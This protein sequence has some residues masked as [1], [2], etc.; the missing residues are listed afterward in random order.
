MDVNADYSMTIDG[1]AARASAAIPVVNPATGEAFAQ[2]PDCTPAQLDEAV[3][4]A[5]TAFKRWRQVPIDERQEL[6]RKAGDVL[7]A[8]ADELARLFTHEQGRPVDGAKQ[9]IQGAAQW[10]HAVST[11]R[12]PVEVSED[13]E[14][15]LIETRYVPLGVICAIAPWNFPVTLSMWKVAPALLAGNTMVLKPS[16]FTPLCTLKIGE[17]FRDVFPPGVLNV[18][19]GGDDL[20]PAMTAHPGFDKISFTGSSATGKRVMESAAKDLKRITLELGG[21]DAAIVL[22]DVDLDEVAQKIFFGAFYNSAQICVATK[23]LYVH[24][25]VY[26]GLRDRL[27]AIAKAVKVGDGAEQGTV[28]GPIQNRRQYDRVMNLLEDARANQLTLIE[29]AAIPDNG[30]FFVPVTIV[31]NPPESSRVVQEEAFGPI[32]P[33][34]KFSDVDEVIDRANASDYG[35]AGA[36][37][38]KDL[39]QA[40]SVARRIETGTVWVNQNLNLR[41]DTPFAGRKQSGFGAE[42]GM[43][44]L[45][46]YMAPQAIYVAK[47]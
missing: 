1:R 12:P 22:P 31:D 33:M 11:M 5:R 42:N 41:P 23:R 13:S 44:G 9:E 26:D 46:E 34:L 8:H 29:G 7:A 15:Q 3:A 39:D 38:S 19:C 35:L 36:I 47:N 17:L 25:A 18:I 20:G 24:E 45:L 43:K 32:L 2:A 10:L 14:Q 4:S 37:W 40:V 16:P 28:L 21:N 30:G 27:A 6:L